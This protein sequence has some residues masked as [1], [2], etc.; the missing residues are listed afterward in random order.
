MKTAKAKT[1]KIYTMNRTSDFWETTEGVQVS[2]KREYFY[3]GESWVNGIRL[4][5]NQ[6]V[7]LPSVFLD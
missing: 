2:V 5:N 3:N 1:A 6:L 4:D 7:K